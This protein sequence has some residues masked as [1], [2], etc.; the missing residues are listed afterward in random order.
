M[1]KL[2]WHNL[3]AFGQEE[4]EWS[5]LLMWLISLAL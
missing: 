4:Q 5:V 2:I 3:V 1:K